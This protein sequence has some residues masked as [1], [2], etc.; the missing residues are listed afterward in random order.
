MSA[1]VFG[2]VTYS[3]RVQ[4]SSSIRKGM[5]LFPTTNPK[6]W[7]SSIVDFH[8]VK[9]SFKRPPRLLRHSAYSTTLLLSLTPKGFSLSPQVP[10]L[11]PI[12]RPLSAQNPSLG[13]LLKTPLKWGDNRT[14]KGVLGKSCCALSVAPTQNRNVNT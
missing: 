7:A 12:P 13:R 8:G 14:L 6:S 1:K 11:F 3:I 4:L 9:R 5:S 10:L 2:F